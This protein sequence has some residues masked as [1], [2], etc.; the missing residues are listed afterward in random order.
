MIQQTYS[1]E[2]LKIKARKNM[3]KAINTFPAKDV[4]D[5]MYLAKRYV[6]WEIDKI[7]KGK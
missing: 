5:T 6:A 7:K 2:E 1:L 4:K 3:F